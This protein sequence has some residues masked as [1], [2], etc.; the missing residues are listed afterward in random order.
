MTKKFVLI[1]SHGHIDI[2]DLLLQIS[3]YS[4]IPNL[5]NYRLYIPILQTVYL[6][7]SFTS[8]KLNLLNSLVAA[9]RIAQ[10]GEPNCWM[11]MI[12]TWLVWPIRLLARV[13]SLNRE[14]SML[15]PWT[16]GRSVSPWSGSKGSWQISN[17]AATASDSK[18]PC[19]QNQ[20]KQFTACFLV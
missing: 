12:V 18:A 17:K 13:A 14:F 20:T 16:W 19:S 10:D 5:L 4:Q 11:T 1:A 15:R 6:V 9:F 3:Y 2:L 8:F 7:N